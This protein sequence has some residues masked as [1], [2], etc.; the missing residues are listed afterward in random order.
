MKPVKIFYVELVH[1]VSGLLYPT[2]DDIVGDIFPAY[3]FINFCEFDIKT[4]TKNL[5]LPT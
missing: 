2:I 4:P 1:S 5:N 3:S